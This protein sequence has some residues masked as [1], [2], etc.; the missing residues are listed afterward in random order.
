M[1]AFDSIWAKGDLGGDLRSK[2]L[3]TP[4]TDSFAPNLGRSTPAAMCSDAD[5]ADR[6]LRA[7]VDDCEA[8]HLALRAL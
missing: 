1:A 7:H 5:I 2:H 8:A 6:L 3:A 4:H